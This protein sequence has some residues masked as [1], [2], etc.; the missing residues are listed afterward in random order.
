ME[1]MVRIES[2]EVARPEIEFVDERG[3]EERLAH[4]AAL[5]RAQGAGCLGWLVTT[6]RRE[7]KGNAVYCLTAEIGEIEIL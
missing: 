5:F 1:I 2:G 4:I 3:P 7:K 6:K